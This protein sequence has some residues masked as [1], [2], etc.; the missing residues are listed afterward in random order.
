MEVSLI[1]L[2]REVNNNA[3]EDRYRTHRNLDA[4]YEQLIW[5]VGELRGITKRLDALEEKPK[6]EVKPQV[7]PKNTVDNSTLF[8]EWRN[9]RVRIDKDGGLITV[10]D[11]WRSFRYW[12]DASP[13]IEKKLSQSAFLDEM[14]K[15]LGLPKDGKIYSGLFVFNTEEDVEAHDA[16]KT[17][18]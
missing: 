9:A 14:T 3:R 6:P 5:I 15:A 13:K 11:L 17:L 12:Y 2:L 18:P 8:L 16:S 1:S 4:V 7:K 10:G